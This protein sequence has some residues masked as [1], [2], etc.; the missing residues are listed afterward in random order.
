[1]RTT[2]TLDDDVAEKLKQFARRQRLSFK[3]AVNT[4]IRKGL[5]SQDRR[6][7]AARVRVRPF[8]SPLRPGV[9]PLRLNQL[10]DD[11][12]LERTARRLRR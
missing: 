10:V 9:D 3:V 5:V 4:V 8:S 11:L 6:G 2:L 7:H 1:M 12:E